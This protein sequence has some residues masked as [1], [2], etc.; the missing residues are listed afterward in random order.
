MDSGRVSTSVVS[1]PSSLRSEIVETQRTAL[2]EWAGVAPATLV[3]SAVYGVREYSRGSVLKR[4]V[5]RVQSHGVPSLRTD[6]TLCR[7]DPCSWRA[8]LSAILNV[9]QRG[10][11]SQW[12]LTITDHSGAGTESPVHLCNTE[13]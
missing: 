4:H 8:V 2:G 13:T 7:A 10:I 12:A 5:D 6:I 11:D 3:K 9:A 1:L